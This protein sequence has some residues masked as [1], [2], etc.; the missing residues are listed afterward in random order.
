MNSIYRATVEVTDYQELELTGP[1]ISVA[2][3]RPSVLGEFDLWYEHMEHDHPLPAYAQ[4]PHRRYHRR[5][6]IY[7]FGT[8]NP[9]PWNTFTRY[10]WTFLGTVI[11]HPTAV[12]HVY[13]GP[14]RGEPIAL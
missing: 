1:P 9:T 13:L 8:G 5:Y 7:V 3:C 4:D 10:A 2:P 6:A 12:W 14:R 11:T